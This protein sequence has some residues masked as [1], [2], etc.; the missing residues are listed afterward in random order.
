MQ[1][2]I[3]KPHNLL[4][5]LSINA[6]L[7]TFNRLSGLFDNVIS[8]SETQL[9]RIYDLN[10]MFI[11]TPITVIVSYLLYKGFTKHNKHT[12]YLLLIS[13]YLVIISTGNHEVTNFLNMHFCSG[14]LDSEICKSIAFNDDTFSTL[15]YF[16]G[17]AGINISILFSEVTTANSNKLVVYINA[18]FLALGI[19]ANSAFED[20]GIDLYIMA[21]VLFVALYQLYIRALKDSS[22]LSISLSHT[23]L[24]LLQL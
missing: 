18:V 15:L 24:E 12:F 16:L 21:L 10:A 4:T 20:I 1:N 3:N 9:M 8:I 6:L 5:L 11:V 22:S 19:I 13:L 23:E 2:F 7:L 17:Y 14:E